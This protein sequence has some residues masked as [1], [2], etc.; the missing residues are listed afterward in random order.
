MK[1]VQKES[2][3]FIEKAHGAYSNKEDINI[4]A[5]GGVPFEVPDDLGK[6]RIEA[7]PALYREATPE[8][9]EYTKQLREEKIIEASQIG[10][11]VS[12]LENNGS[13]QPTE[14]K[15]FDAS[16][17]LISKSE[18][19]SESLGEL[20]RPQLF[21][22]AEVLELTVPKNIGTEK[23]IERILEKLAN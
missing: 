17:Y 1:I 22:I 9:F 23:L 14:P 15:D 2:G 20:E 4:D 13:P 11:D 21:Q 8:D 12:P 3:K 19:T 5:I 16:D 18:H 7:S 6:A 10:A